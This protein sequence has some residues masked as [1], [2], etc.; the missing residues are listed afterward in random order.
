MIFLV[1]GIRQLI[2]KMRQHCMLDYNT[3]FDRR[4]PATVLGVREIRELVSSQLE[5]SQIES[6]SLLTG[7]FIN[8]NYRLVLRDNTS[9]VLR[10]AARSG[11]LKKELSV[12]KQVHGD[13]L[14][15]QLEG[16]CAASRSGSD[17]EF[18]GRQEGGSQ[19][20]SNSRL[21]NY[22]D[23]GIG[24]EVPPVAAAFPQCL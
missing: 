24:W 5:P 16:S 18:V 19:D 6:V 12:L 7:G 2:A 11:A 9:L 22:G 23:G 10:I 4:E 21:G 3:K 8:S 14:A 17:G 15:G 13:R 1:F 20:A